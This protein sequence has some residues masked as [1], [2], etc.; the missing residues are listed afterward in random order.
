MTNKEFDKRDARLLAYLRGELTDED[1]ERLQEELAE[2]EAFAAKLE[3]LLLGE[4]K[5]P[6]QPAQIS[7]P[8]EKQSRI[9]RRGKWRMRLGNSAFTLGIAFLAGVLLFAV[10]TWI[11]TSM[12]DELLRVTRSM[13]NFTQPGI[14]AGSSGS[15]IGLLYGNIEME[16]REQVGADQKNAGKIESTNLLWLVSAQPKW[17]NGVRDVKLF[18]RFPSEAMTPEETEY[19][20]TPAWKAMEKLP[21]GTV[22]QLAISFDRLLTYE[23][24]YSLIS[25]HVP[26]YEQE[27]VWLAVD[28]GE[29]LKQADRGEGNVILSAGEIWGFSERSLDY[30]NAPIQV[31][32]E[33]NRRTAAYVAEM[34]YLAEQERLSRAVGRGLMWGQPNI[35]ERYQYLQ[36]NGVGIYGAVIT[37]P[38][39]ELLKLKEETSI[40]AAFLGQV[41]WWNWE[42]PAASGTQNSW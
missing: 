39:K 32:A 19:L 11:G 33:G 16:L 4:E 28:T 30:G 1:K 12:Y 34:K 15:Q 36:E 9:L 25:R 3:H 29:E 22:S 6:E 27:T 35:Q 13:V 20:R 40:T 37:G 26:D 14:T 18:F 8:E 5:E 23:E 10:N 21:E 7:L 38:T 24:Y 42:R 31:N 41:D 17:P 2:D